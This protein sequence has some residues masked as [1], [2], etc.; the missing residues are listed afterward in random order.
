[1]KKLLSYKIPVTFLAVFCTCSL[2]LF[3]FFWP[4]P[5]SDSK[6]HPNE[7]V[8]FFFVRRWIS[9]FSH[10]QTSTC[11]P[12]VPLFLATYFGCH[13]CWQ[14][15]KSKT[16]FTFSFPLII[17][18][19]Q[20]E[21]SKPDVLNDYLSKIKKNKIFFFFNYNKVDMSWKWTSA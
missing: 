10:V 14:R 5:E 2:H 4:S 9:A 8:V 18:Q 21:I 19:I 20:L 1:M 7:T 3:F 11:S 13:A 17:I 12:S 15:C 6:C 16:K